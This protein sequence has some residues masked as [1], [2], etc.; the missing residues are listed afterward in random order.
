[1]ARIAIIGGGSMGEALLVG[2]AEGGPSGQGPRSRRADARTCPLPGRH[3]LGADDRGGRGRRDRR[4]SSSS[5]SNRP[6]P[7]RWWARSP[8]RAA[9]AE[10]NSV[11]QV[12]VSVVAGVT[13]GFYESRLPAGSPVV[14]VMP[15]APALVGAGISAL[16]AGRFATPEQLAEVSALFEC[17]GWGPHG[18][19]KPT[20]RG[21]RGVR[22]RAGV[23]L[24]FRGGI[25]R[26]RR[27]QTGSTG[28]SRPIWWCKPWR[29]RR[30]CC[31]IAST[32]SEQ[33]VPTS[34]WTPH[35]PGCGPS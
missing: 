15:N 14:R 11:E 30:R 20:R 2:A 19:G 22:F 16:A 10:S 7:N 13:V 17:V 3:V 31:S 9:R 28:R 1:M 5:R 24:P 8:R 29:V 27:S 6:M 32:A 18:A 35:P 26:R 25:G 33:P 23:L 34:D 12:L 21:H 4:A